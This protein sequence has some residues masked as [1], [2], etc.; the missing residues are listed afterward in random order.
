MGDKY[1]I[2]VTGLHNDWKSE[3]T[4]SDKKGVPIMRA[5]CYGKSMEFFTSEGVSKTDTNE[6]YFQ[7]FGSRSEK[8]NF[9]RRVAVNEHT[10]EDISRFETSFYGSELLEL[11]SYLKMN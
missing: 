11:M 7:M 2:Q 10:K 4:I 3:V 8:N 9:K 1:N 5:K 6:P